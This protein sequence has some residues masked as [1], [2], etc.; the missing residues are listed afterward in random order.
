MSNEF[1]V[2]KIGGGKDWVFRAEALR[3]KHESIVRNERRLRELGDQLAD[4]SS[5]AGKA[6]CW[7]VPLESAVFTPKLETELKLTG[8]GLRR[9]VEVVDGA[10][11]VLKAGLYRIVLQ[12]KLRPTSST[13]P[14]TLP[15]LETAYGRVKVNDKVKA[16]FTNTW[17][18]GHPQEGIP[19]VMDF[20]AFGQI[21]V[22][23]KAGDLLT[24]LL[25][26][27]AFDHK[28][29][30]VQIDGDLCSFSGELLS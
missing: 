21:C 20:T 10:I 25:Q 22:D 18:P 8:D 28:S 13:I 24:P 9:G 23:C 30:G 3:H 29:M 16:V 4:L 12:V 27:S 7:F 17:T 5:D 1:E 11:K 2:A 14:D 19:G 26:T 6:P 15:T